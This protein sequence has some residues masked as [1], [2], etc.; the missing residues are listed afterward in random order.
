MM[1]NVQL[2]VE[3]QPEKLRFEKCIY[4]ISDDFDF[5]RKYPGTIA[6]LLR[7][8][9]VNLLNDINVFIQFLWKPAENCHIFSQPL[10]LFL[11]FLPPA[12]CVG[13]PGTSGVPAISI[14]IIP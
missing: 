8:K 7:D 6:Y 3:R 14:I 4:K 2:K 5:L 13:T 11:S 10:S 1:I 9:P 12:A